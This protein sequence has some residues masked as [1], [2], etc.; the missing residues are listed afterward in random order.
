MMWSCRMVLFALLLAIGV[1]GAASA[2][3]QA[4][5]VGVVGASLSTCAS[6]V[7]PGDTPQAMFAHPERFDCTSPQ[8]AHGSGDYWILSGPLPPGT[9]GARPIRVRQASLSQ[10]R[11]AVYAL[12]ADGRITG[13][14][15]DQI[16]I[17]R[18]LRLGAVIEHRF[19]PGDAPITRLLWRVDGASNLRGVV[20]GARVAS[21][22]DSIRSDL[23]F[24]AFYAAFLGLVS[25]LLI[26]N[27]ALWNVLRHDFQL[28]YCGLLGCVLLYAL[29]SSGLLAW[30]LP[31]IE[32]NRRILFNY[33]VLCWG[34]SAAL[35][36]CAHFFESH[37]L[38]GWPQ[39][40]ITVTT[41][42]F[43][44]LGVLF[45]AVGSVAMHPL[46]RLYSLVMFV[47]PGVVMAVLWRAWQRR[48][49]FLWM[50]LISWISP[51]AMLAVRSAFNLGLVPWSFWIDNST[52]VA[53]A[54]ETLVASMAI[55]HRILMLSRERDEAVRQEAISRELAD[56]DPL[57]G[58]LNRRAFL[59]RAIPADGPRTLM[60]FD[61]DHFKQVNDTI[62][63]DGGDEVLRLFA[64]TLRYHA[65][66]GVLVA[67]MG[68]EEFALLGEEDA[69]PDPELMLASVRGERLP[70]DLRITSSIGICHGPLADEN[71]WKR[72]YRLADQ[73]LF[74]AK[75]AGRDRAGRAPPAAMAA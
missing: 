22:G 47:S 49:R 36:F 43:G 6:R 50:F 52:L 19:V 21:D 62:G 74:Q 38:E 75:T 41:W 58:L 30:V 29:S 40:L 60:L 51:I 27:L 72:L 24:A 59:A 35:T 32:N 8:T 14:V 10:D 53:M 54:I 65:R 9:D 56:T 66:T 28:A 16:G 69:M 55:A 34:M 61:I 31:G 20:V 42:T 15:N 71:D 57:T 5:V 45:M 17:S 44:V 11:L 46:D 39:R 33:I 12:A 2:R 13:I 70:F 26:Y 1:L 37:I 23:L 3:A 73:A 7:A 18:H 67:R 63:H 25:G 48:S 64:R 4:G 68:G